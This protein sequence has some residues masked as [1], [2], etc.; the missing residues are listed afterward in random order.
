MSTITTPEFLCAAVFEADILYTPGHSPLYAVLPLP[1]NNPIPF[2][3]S[4]TSTIIATPSFPA[5][6]N[7]VPAAIVI[8]PVGSP[9]A[10]PLAAN[11]APVTGFA[12]P[13]KLSTVS[14]PFSCSQGSQLTTDVPPPLA[15]PPAP[16][17]LLLPP[18][19]GGAGSPPEDGGMIPASTSPIW[20]Q[21]VPICILSLTKRSG[22][23]PAQWSKNW[24]NA[25]MPHAAPRRG[26]A[27]RLPLTREGSPS[28]IFVIST[29]IVIV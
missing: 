22:L 14:S 18:P 21:E 8:A 11:P 10:I 25:S 1:L 23:T 17:L 4:A 19:P 5:A 7:A 26:C 6:E 13:I 24:P 29:G 3:L 9:L 2:A 15:P 16:P 12:P 20:I 28:T 27:A